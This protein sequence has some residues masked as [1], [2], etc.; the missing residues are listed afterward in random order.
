MIKEHPFAPTE[1][2]FIFTDGEERVFSDGETFF[3]E[4]DCCH[5]CREEAEANNTPFAFADLR[6]SFGCYAGRY[7]DKCWPNSGYRD[8]TDPNAEFDPAYA[9][10]AMYEDEY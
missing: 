4:R 7:C 9:G 5:H 3:D 2:P 10:E 1:H 8:A 6:T